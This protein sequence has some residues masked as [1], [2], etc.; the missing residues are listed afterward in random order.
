METT[1]PVSTSSIGALRSGNR[2]LMPL[3]H[4]LSQN[5]PILYNCL[6]SI[7]WDALLGKCPTYSGRVRTAR[8]RLGQF[9][10]IENVVCDAIDS[11]KDGF[12]LLPTRARHGQ[13][14]ILDRLPQV[15]SP[16]HVPTTLWERVRCYPHERPI[17]L[18]RLW[19]SMSHRTHRIVRR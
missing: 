2:V 14:T 19:V 17:A 5:Y 8:P 3:G 10:Y 16:L 11:C 18:N 9:L 7:T 1:S 4:S 13:F 12:G 15:N 6:R